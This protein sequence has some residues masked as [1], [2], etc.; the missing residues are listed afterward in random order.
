MNSNED[1]GKLLTR[2]GRIQSR[3]EEG[4]YLTLLAWQECYKNDPRL[5]HAPPRIGTNPFTNEPV[6]FKQ[7]ENQRS[8]RRNG[9]WVAWFSWTRDEETPRDRGM[10][11]VYVKDEIASEMIRI[12]EQIAQSLNAV[13]VTESQSE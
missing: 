11:D 2:Y 10:I 6:T 4:G 9:T 1:L 7:P 3:T 8:I 5:E 12:A 13:F